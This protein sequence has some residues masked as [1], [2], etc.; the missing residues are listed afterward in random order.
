MGLSSGPA[1]RGQGWAEVIL[2]CEIRLGP[3]GMLFGAAL[4][5]LKIH[6]G[7]LNTRVHICRSLSNWLDRSDIFIESYSIASSE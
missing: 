6:R 7:A 4:G 1:T 3:S 2:A 5:A